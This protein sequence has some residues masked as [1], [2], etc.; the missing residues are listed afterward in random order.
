MRAKGRFA[1]MAETDEGR[2]RLV[3][4]IASFL[5]T[6]GIHNVNL[7]IEV[8]RLKKFGADLDARLAKA[9]GIAT[10]ERE[11]ARVTRGCVIEALDELLTFEVPG[12]EDS[13]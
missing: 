4:L 12:K 8:A 10:T 9:L 6:H 13:N 1:Q 11:R 2:K 5:V 3:T 7:E